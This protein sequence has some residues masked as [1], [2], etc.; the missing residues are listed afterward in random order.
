MLFWGVRQNNRLV[1]YDQIA[2]PANFDGSVPIFL[3]VKQNQPALSKLKLVKGAIP[4]S[5]SI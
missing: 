2:D 5:A 3:I 4:V 1:A